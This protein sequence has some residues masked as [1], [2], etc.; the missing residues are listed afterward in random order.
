MVWKGL[1]VAVTRLA[2]SEQRHEMPQGLRDRRPWR[3]ALARTPGLDHCFRAGVF[4]VGLVVFLGGAALWLFSTLLTTPL[5]LAGLWIWSWEFVWARRLLHKFRYWLSRFWRRVKRRPKR[6]TVV[7][8][9]GVLSGAA[10]WWASF[11]FGLL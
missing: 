8:A 11:E 9:L 1:V 6:W 5:I 10:V 2:P 3:E 4:V 7:T